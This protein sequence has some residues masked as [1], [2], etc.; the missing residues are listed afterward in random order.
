MNKYFCNI[1]IFNFIAF[2]L[3]LKAQEY[4][5]YKTLSEH[6][7]EISHI[8]F[9][10]EDNLLVSGDKNGHII[11]WDINAGIVKKKFQHHSDKITDIT[12]NKTGDLMSI[13]SYDG[14]ISI[15]SI[16]DFQL[17]NSIEIPAIPSYLGS[18]GNEPT[19]VDFSSFENFVYFGGYNMILSKASI[20]SPQTTNLYSVAGG[21]LTC[22]VFSTDNKY[23]IFGALNTIYFYDTQLKTISKKFNKSNNYDDYVCEIAILPNSNY[24]AYWAYNGLVHFLNLSTN[25]IDFSISATSNKGTSNIAFSFDGKYMVTGNESGKT[26]IW[27]LENKQIIQTLEGHTNIVTCFAFSEDASCIV[28]A[29]DD[30]RINIWKKSSTTTPEIIIQNTIPQT[31]QNRIIEIQENITVSDK[32]VEFLVWD[33]SQIDGDIISLN[34]NGNWVLENYTLTAAKK[35]IRVNLNQINNYLIMFAHN[36]GTISPNTA[37]ISIK[38]GNSEKILSLQSTM[39]KCGSIN[40]KVQ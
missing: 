39:N 11:V 7:S 14:T 29:S 1:L 21:G 24:L 33:R 5:L 3:N 23:F 36:E 35:S 31:I 37:A 38:S 28:T 13:A 30:K 10:S 16:P 19:F 9:R 8:A 15:W 26:K 4:S 17:I 2:Q 40:I 22:G 34:V 32:V 18:K 12:F 20:Y 25:L 27:N 6:N